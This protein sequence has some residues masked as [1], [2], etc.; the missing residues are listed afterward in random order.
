MTHKKKIKKYVAIILTGIGLPLLVNL[1]WDSYSDNKNDSNFFIGYN[2]IPLP[3]KGTMK[4]FIGTDPSVHNNDILLVPVITSLNN[5]G[6]TPLSEARINYH[7]SDKKLCPPEELY[8]FV[9]IKGNITKEDV[10]LESHYYQDGCESVFSVR[11]LNPHR[12]FN[13]TT[14][15]IANYKKEGNAYSDTLPFYGNISISIEA[16]NT[17]RKKYEIDYHFVGKRNIDE[18]VSWYKE[19]YTKERAVRD[20]GNYSYWEYLYKLVNCQKE[21]NILM[22]FPSLKYIYDGNVKIWLPTD[23]TADIKATVYCPYSWSLL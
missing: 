4:V 14:A 15:F 10:K 19:S 1:I 8:Q 23:N 3:E 17:K 11:N 9:N 2:E 21:T 5:N 20:R 16:N 18:L 13:P 22:T 7:L 6:D 12:T